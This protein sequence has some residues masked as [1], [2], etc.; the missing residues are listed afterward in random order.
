MKIFL[1]MDRS[2]LGESAAA[3]VGKWIGQTPC[4]MRVFS[5]VHPKDLHN[6]EDSSTL[7]NT[8][9]SREERREAAELVQPGL[10]GPIAP[11]RPRVHHRLVEYKSQAVER[12]CREREAYLRTVLRRTIPSAVPTFEVE[13]GEDVAAAIMSAADAYGADMI[14]MGTHGHSVVHH[15]FLGT[16]PERVT[17]DARI[18]VL[19]V[20]PAALEAATPKQRIAV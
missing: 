9:E 15:P 10:Y 6:M 14:A 1:V 20:G 4:E 16:V 11:I 13:L 3:A 12:A 2:E 8:A 7:A 19:L 5:V 18:P 17:R